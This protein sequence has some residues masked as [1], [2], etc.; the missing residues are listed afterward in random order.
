[1]KI[2]KLYSF[3]TKSVLSLAALLFA[4]CFLLFNF[5]KTALSLPQQQALVERASL[6]VQSFLSKFYDPQQKYFRDQY[7]FN[8]QQ[9]SPLT[10]YWTFAQGFN[11]IVDNAFRVSRNFTNANNDLSFPHYVKLISD[12]YTGQ[13]NIGWERP[14]IDDMNWMAL[15]LFWSYQLTRNQTYLERCLYLYSKIVV[16]WDDTCCG[17]MKGGIWW[18]YAHS[19]KATAS[20]AGPSLLSSLLYQETREE[21]YLKF[22]T[23]VFSFWYDHMVNKSDNSVCDH[24]SAQNGF[25]ECQWRFTYNE[26]LMIGAATHLFQMTRNETFLQIATNIANFMITQEVIDSKV[27]GP[28]LFDGINCVSDCMQFKG[29]GFRYLTFLQSQLKDKNLSMYLKIQNVLQNCVESLWNVARTN[30]L[31]LFSVQWQGPSQEVDSK[32]YQAQMNSAVMAFSLSV[33]QQL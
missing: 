29:I 9:Q 4:W 5:S 31:N 17:S 10:G 15:T 12:L 18:D 27:G 30:E 21:H 7:T 8:Q 22:S 23:Q 2:F 28:V 19:Q 24:I 32:F 3:K 1:M 33:I 13:D 20:N 26:G 11:A 6:A 16:N 14:Y 25:K